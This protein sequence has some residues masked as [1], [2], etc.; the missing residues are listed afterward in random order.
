MQWRR[1]EDLTCPV[2]QVKLEIS[3]NKSDRLVKPFE[4]QATGPIDGVIGYGETENEARRDVS[5]KIMT[6]C[7]DAGCYPNSCKLNSQPIPYDKVH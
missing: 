5:Q 6:Q 4:V 1:K 3:S 7:V 2:G